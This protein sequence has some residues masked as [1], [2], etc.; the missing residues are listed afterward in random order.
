MQSSTPVFV[1]LIKTKQHQEEDFLQIMQFC[2]QCLNQVYM[3]TCFQIAFLFL[4]RS[5]LHP[6]KGKYAV[7]Q[8]VYKHLQYSKTI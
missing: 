8:S 7:L 4:P 6:I 2:K 1:T 5:Q 3:L